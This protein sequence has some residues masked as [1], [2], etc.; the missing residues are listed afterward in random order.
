MSPRKSLSERAKWQGEAGVRGRSAQEIFSVIMSMHLENQ[1]YELITQPRKL[2]SIYGKRTTGRPHGIKP[3][4]EIIDVSSGKAIFGEI[5]RQKA[6]GNAHERACKYMMPSMMRAIRESSNQPDHVVPF[7]W[8]FAEGIALDKNYRQE[9]SFWFKGFEANVTFWP[10]VDDH[11]VIIEHFE[12][13]I[14]PILSNSSKPKHP[15]RR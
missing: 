5:K 10:K 2:N 1:K 12:K 8:I 6:G 4:F 14:R 11:T 9:I 15:R 7:W 13:H 3:E